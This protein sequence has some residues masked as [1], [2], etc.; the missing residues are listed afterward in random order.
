MPTMVTKKN[1]SRLKTWL[2]KNSVYILPILSVIITAL[3]VWVSYM[4]Y[5][6]Q[7]EFSR[8]STEIG[9]A[10]LNNMRQEFL[11][12]RK[13]TAFEVIGTLYEDLYKFGENNKYVIPKLE[14]AAEE[15]KTTGKVSQSNTI[16]NTEN[17]EMYLNSFESIYEQCK[18]GVIQYEDVRV[19]FE[20]LIGTTCNNDQVVEVLGSR[21]SGL[22]YLCQL[23]HPDSKLGKKVDPA[24]NGCRKP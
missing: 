16:V 20:Y 9:E 17:L 21:G 4:S 13:K 24:V 11:L 15:R 10:Q 8:R 1:R 5:L 23:F 19:N 2:K 6:Q 12:T 18:G 7:T 3:A 22:K 14:Q